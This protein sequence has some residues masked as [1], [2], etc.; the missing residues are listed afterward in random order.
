MRSRRIAASIMEKR[1]KTVRDPHWG[2]GGA[3][4]REGYVLREGE[5]GD[6]DC[7]RDNG[8]V[9]ALQQYATSKKTTG[10]GKEVDFGLAWWELTGILSEWRD[11]RRRWEVQRAK[12]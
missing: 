4:Q 8:A 1:A 2:R 6:R 11:T 3:D 7:Q 10:G 5:M 12:G 9:G